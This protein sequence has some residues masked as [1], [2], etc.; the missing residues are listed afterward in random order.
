MALGEFEQMILLAVLHLGD[1]AYG[2]S[3]VDAI[4]ERSGRAV[5]RGS[6]YITFDRLEAKGY[7]TS[8]LRSAVEARRGKQRRYITITQEGLAA[9]RESREALLGMWQGLEPLLE[10]KP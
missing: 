6:L 1:E 4:E 3:I 9:L 5:A 7:I 10:T 8:T 2:V